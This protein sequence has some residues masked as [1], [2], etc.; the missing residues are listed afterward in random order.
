MGAAAI[1]DAV[2]GRLRADHA[3]EVTLFR[4]ELGICV[5]AGRIDVAAVNGSLT[6]CEVKSARD[7][8]GRLAGQIELYGRVVDYAILAV[9]RSRPQ[10]ILRR[11]PSW[12]G[13]WHVTRTA[14]GEVRLEALREATRN[15]DVQ[16][17]AVAQLLWRDEAFDVLRARDLHRGLAS[18]TR[19]RLWEVIARELAVD[20]VR[21]VVR[22]RLKARR[23]W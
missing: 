20:E 4:R 2:E 6:G 7:G 8:L 1:A 17:L 21:D 11:L 19:W 18:A 14:D 5:G 9:E 10:L 12:W 15:P 22:V 3:R 16:P 23:G 13:V